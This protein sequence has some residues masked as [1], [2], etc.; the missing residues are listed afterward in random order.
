MSSQELKT[1]N[2]PEKAQR[3]M[4]R[5]A[6]AKHLG[7]FEAITMNFLGKSDGRAELPRQAQNGNWESPRLRKESSA[8]NEFCDRAWGTTQLDL[9]NDYT[10]VGVLI[11]TIKRDEE[12]LEHLLMKAPQA[13]DELYLTTRMSG[14]EVLDD[15]QIRARRGREFAKDTAPYYARIK[16]LEDGISTA[17]AQLDK[18]HNHIIETNNTTRL[19]CERLKNHTEQRQDAYW[20]AALRTHP[21]K[22]EM[23]VT[24]APLAKSEAELIY[25]MQ[26]KTL[27]GEA[28]AMLV[29]RERLIL[30]REP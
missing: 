18:R 27:E 24:P 30:L 28:V 9:K 14:E 7:F 23:P 16:T 13:P 2:T 17:Y 12:A 3:R 19:V 29:R 8:Y 10:A 5:S 21:A 1:H 22:K 20:N 26:H 6:K 4:L 15:N 11:D 25:T